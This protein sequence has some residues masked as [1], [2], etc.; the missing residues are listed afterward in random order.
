M[1]P[2]TADSV[3]GCAALATGA[4]TRQTTD[5]RALIWS[6]YTEVRSSYQCS[7]IA[8]APERLGSITWTNHGSSDA[9]PC[10]VEE[11]LEIGE[12]EAAL[13]GQPRD[14]AVDCVQA[15]S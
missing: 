10:P 6:F 13:A 4:P 12:Q 15:L 2:S 5:P 7:A 1:A 8:V 3:R 9:T 14:A 11:P